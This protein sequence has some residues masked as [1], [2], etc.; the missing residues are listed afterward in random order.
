MRRLNKNRFIMMAIL[1]AGINSNSLMANQISGKALTNLNLTRE[2]QNLNGSLFDSQLTL[3]RQT[4]RL[5]RN[6]TGFSLGGE[7]SNGIDARTDLMLDFNVAQF[8]IFWDYKEN[9]NTT[10]VDYDKTNMTVL[11][12]KKI[13]EGGTFGVG[14][15]HK[16]NKYVNSAKLKSDSFVMGGVYAKD[17]NGF[18][19]NFITG[20]DLGDYKMKKSNQNTGDFFGY[21]V[22]MTNLVI[23]DFDVQLLDYSNL[24]LGFRTIFWGHTNSS[25]LNSTELNSK[26]NLSNAFIVGMDLGRTFWITDRI[27]IALSTTFEYEKE[28]MDE[29]RWEDSLRYNGNSYEYGPI[30]KTEDYGSFKAYLRGY[31]TFETG[32]KLGGFLKFE[33]ERDVQAGMEIRIN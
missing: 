21:S 14:Y 24:S 15:S 10:G 8:G 7:I 12:L 11:L 28:L 6:E 26:E 13:G 32:I 9:E 2:Y 17:F 16:N 23:K 33:T 1:F 20:M 4:V 22:G 19:Y 31:L 27:G 3:M 30:S 18:R 29:K 25:S 5:S